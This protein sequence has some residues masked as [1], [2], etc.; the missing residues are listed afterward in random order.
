MSDQRKKITP[1]FLQGPAVVHDSILRIFR[2]RHCAALLR[3]C[4]V[5]LL[6]CCVDGWCRNF[7]LG[8][9]YP[10]GRVGGYAHVGCR[11]MSDYAALIRPTVGACILSRAA[12]SGVSDYAALIRPTGWMHAYCFERQIQGCRITALIRPTGWV[13]AYCC[14]RQIQGC[15]I[16]LR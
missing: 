15:R 11:A 4:V 9:R 12:N 3:C 6:R 14:E 7:G 10:A 16:T 1:A 5:A 13:H 8:A 2:T